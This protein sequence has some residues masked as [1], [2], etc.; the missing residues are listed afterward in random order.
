MELGDQTDPELLEDHVA[1]ILGV[2]PVSSSD[3]LHTVTD[4]CADRSLLLVLDNCEHL[5]DAVA[6]FVGAILR[7]C[8]GVKILATSRESRWV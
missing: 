2:R 7:R 8:A 1:V 4:Y 6:S 3:P 5:V